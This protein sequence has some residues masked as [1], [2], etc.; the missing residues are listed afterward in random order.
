MLDQS[1]ASD[2]KVWASIHQLKLQVDR[3]QAV[4]ESNS[5]EVRILTLKSGQQV[6]IKIPYNLKKFRREKT[7]LLALSHHS[8]VPNLLD[9]YEIGEESAMVLSYVDGI[10]VSEAEVL[11]E[12][13]AAQLGEEMARI[14]LV[15]MEDFEGKP[16]WHSLLKRNFSKF[17]QAIK[18]NHDHPTW[19]E[20]SDIF[21]KHLAQIPNTKQACLIHFDLRLGNVLYRN[22]NIVGI[23]DFESSRGGSGE[24]DFFK[25]WKE[26][27]RKRPSLKF[28]MLTAYKAI[29]PLPFDVDQVLNLYYLYHSVGGISWCVERNKLDAPFYEENKK[30]VE[31]ALT[32]I[33]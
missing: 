1:L 14:H 21:E 12:Y 2:Q 23:I 4:P 11:D 17:I 9:W 28:P 19:D 26:V 18:Q 6:V 15:E 24:M 25:L 5:S 10:P 32:M 29:K 20:L 3:I 13:M 33:S 30:G 31:E 8:K 16:H 7:A 27:W 22:N